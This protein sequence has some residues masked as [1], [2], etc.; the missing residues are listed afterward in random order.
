VKALRDALAEDL[1]DLRTENGQLLEQLHQVQ[2]GLEHEMERNRGARDEECVRLRTEVESLA[3][4]RADAEAGW[5]QRL[6]FVETENRELL[7]QLHHTQEILSESIGAKKDMDVVLMRCSRTMV[8]ARAL[9]EEI[10][11]E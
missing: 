7:A 8:R 2:E 1:A 6:A 3:A 5:V 11:G 4:E 10:S 9:I